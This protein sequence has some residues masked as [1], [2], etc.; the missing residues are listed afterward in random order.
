MVKIVVDIAPMGAVRMTQRG[1]FAKP[2][3]QRYMRYKQV[4]G[5]AA[6]EQIKQPLNGPLRVK[7]A[8]YYPIPMSFTKAK[9][10]DAKAGLILPEVKPDLDNVVK[11]CF[12]ALNSIAWKDDKQVV[13][14]SSI[15]RYSENPRIEIE[16]EE[17]VS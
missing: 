17:V 5:W 13:E 1:K 10:A 3:P 7:M 6:R 4:I 11:G 16:I 15:K 8:F 9:K 14:E 2:L 12:D